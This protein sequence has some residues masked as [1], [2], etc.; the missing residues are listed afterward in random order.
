MVMEVGGLV[1][2]L[3][4]NDIDDGDA[5]RKLRGA[6]IAAIVNIKKNKLGY[7]VPSQSG[8]G[9]YVVNVDD[10][11]PFCSCPD[12]ELRQLHCKHVYSVEFLIQRE[13]QP[14]G[15]TLETKAV[16]VKYTQD[17]TAYNKAQTNEGEHFRVLLRDLC[18]TIV[19]PPPQRT[20]RPRLPLSDMVFAMGIKVYSHKSGRRSISFIK[21]AKDKGL[22]DR[23]PHFNSLLRYMEKPEMNEV[24]REL[25]Q[26]SALP[27]VPVEHDFAVDSSGFSTSYYHRWYSHK[28]QR[29]IEEAIWVK[30]HIC[31][32][33]KTNIVTDAIATEHIGNDSPHLKPLIENTAEYFAIREVSGDKA[34]LSK[35]N[36][37][38]VNSLGGMPFIPFKKNSV[39]HNSKQKH[40]YL[41]EKMYYYFRY[42]C[43]DFLKHYH[44]RS[45]VE[46]TFSMLKGN[47]GASVNGRKARSQ[48]NEVLVKILVHNIVVLIQEMYEL[49]IVVDFLNAKPVPIDRTTPF[50]LSP[51]YMLSEN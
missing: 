17:W 10:D 3:G 2:A 16:Q 26:L 21:D 47:Y 25:I 40:D 38:L 14:D 1:T 46:T 9:N 24:L 29:E 31:T 4:P 23:I 8:S 15:S 35:G 45:N 5:G 41:W 44:K 34:Y 7:V 27:L 49:G 6:A 37:R 20:G 42:N 39:A 50:A 32:G 19:E 30:N 18:D 11:E 22:I 28:H 12:F 33:V 48:C 13:E 51:D 36:L 43:S